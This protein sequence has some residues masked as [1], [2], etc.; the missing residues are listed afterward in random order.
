[1]PE[2]R[3]RAGRRWSLEDRLVQYGMFFVGI[4]LIGD[5]VVEI[6]AESGLQSVEHFTGI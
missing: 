6:N 2:R 1:M 3:N 5:G 4:D